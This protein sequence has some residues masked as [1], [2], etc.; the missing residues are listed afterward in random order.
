MGQGQGQG[1]GQEDGQEDFIL[2]LE[3]LDLSDFEAGIPPFVRMG[4]PEGEDEEQEGGEGELDVG[5]DFDDL[6]PVSPSDFRGGDEA[7]EKEGDAATNTTAYEATADTL[8]VNRKSDPIPIPDEDKDKEETDKEEADDIPP[9]P[10]S[11]PEQEQN[12]MQWTRP[13]RCGA[14]KGFRILESEL[15]SAEARGEREVLV[16]CEGCSLWVRVG[17]DV[18]EG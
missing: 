5:I 3:L 8:P 7:G 11:P 6:R 16:G 10:P 18:E 17:F 14:E 15:E 1:Q 9:S 4:T 12:E 2:G 13:C